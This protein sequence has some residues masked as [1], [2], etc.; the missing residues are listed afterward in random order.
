M[1]FESISN[2]KNVQFIIILLEYQLNIEDGIKSGKTFLLDKIRFDFSDKLSFKLISLKL[3]PGEILN[4]VPECIDLISDCVY[5][6]VIVHLGQIDEDIRK[7][8]AQRNLSGWSFFNFFLAKESKALTLSDLGLFSE[9]LAVYDELETLLVELA[10]S[11]S[12][13]LNLNF[14]MEKYSKIS[15]M[16]I[17]SS[18]WGFLRQKIFDNQITQ[19][20]FYIYLFSRQIHLLSEIQD[21]SQVLKR[22]KTFICSSL[23]LN[24]LDDSARRLWVFD[25]IFSVIKTIDMNFSQLENNNE[26]ANF[27]SDILILAIDQVFWHIIKLHYLLF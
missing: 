8:S 17:N 2:K 16:D 26:S 6:S 23:F 21:Y 5:H 14:S 7:M 4:S 13:E 27:L 15:G 1:W 19:Y 18:N 10:S 20:E 25:L 22:C 3:M 24:F 9:S 11:D 12:K